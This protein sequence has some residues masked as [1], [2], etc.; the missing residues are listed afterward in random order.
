MGP[1]GYILYLSANSDAIGILRGNQLPTH[2]DYL[3]ILAIDENDCYSH[4][5]LLELENRLPLHKGLIGQKKQV[6]T[7]GP[8]AKAQR[9][10][11]SW[12]LKLTQY[13]SSSREIMD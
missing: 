5:M 1:M 11:I 13:S 6:P 4:L 7:E 12:T 10:R 8:P 2:S 9:I 3:Y